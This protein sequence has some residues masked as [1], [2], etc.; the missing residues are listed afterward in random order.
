MLNKQEEIICVGGKGEVSFQSVG[1]VD[2][3][4]MDIGG[5]KGGIS[6]AVSILNAILREIAEHPNPL[7][8]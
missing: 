1:Y 8:V 6:A 7:D 2:L 5:K 3:G 4:W